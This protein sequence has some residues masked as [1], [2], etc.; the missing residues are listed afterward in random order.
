MQEQLSAELKQLY[1]R[2]RTP[3]GFVSLSYRTIVYLAEPLDWV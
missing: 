1:E 3:S 2:S